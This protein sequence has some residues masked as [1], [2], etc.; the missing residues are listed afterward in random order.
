MRKT[1]YA[2]RL[3]IDKACHDTPD[4]NLYEK[5]MEEKTKYIVTKA[6]KNGRNSVLPKAG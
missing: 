4:L 6:C 5:V 1:M 3:Y 2:V